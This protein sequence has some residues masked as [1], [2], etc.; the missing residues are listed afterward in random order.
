MVKALHW[1]EIPF[2][3]EV[4]WMLPEGPKLYW[5]G[6]ITG[7]AGGLGRYIIKKNKWKHSKKRLHGL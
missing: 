2:N 1:M 5:R 7:R 6:H 4:V 3:G